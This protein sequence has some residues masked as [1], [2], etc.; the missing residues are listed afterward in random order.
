MEFL[1]MMK[2]SLDGDAEDEVAGIDEGTQD[3]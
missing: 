1:T 3:Q 2:V